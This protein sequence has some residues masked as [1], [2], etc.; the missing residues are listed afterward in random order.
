MGP[1][2]RESKSGIDDHH[3]R[4]EEFKRSAQVPSGWGLMEHYENH[5]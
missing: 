5:I 4:R 2:S 3:E 1:R